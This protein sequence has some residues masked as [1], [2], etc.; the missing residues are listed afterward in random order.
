MKLY[1]EFKRIETVGLSLVS[2][3]V[4]YLDY[5]KVDNEALT[6]PNVIPLRDDNGKLVG[7]LVLIKDEKVTET[8][9]N[10]STYE[11]W[12]QDALEGVRNELPQQTPSSSRLEEILKHVYFCGAADADRHYEVRDMNRAINEYTT[13]TSNR[14]DT[15]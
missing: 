11:D 1:I 12:L 15:L 10:S 8:Y 14:E 6:K 3:L 7:N 5:L 13:P 4:R 9:V 2:R